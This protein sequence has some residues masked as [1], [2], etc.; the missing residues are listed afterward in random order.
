MPDQVEYLIT[1][2]I[3]RQIGQHALDVGTDQ[4]NHALLDHRVGDVDGEKDPGCVGLLRVSAVVLGGHA[5]VGT[6]TQFCNRKIKVIKLLRTMLWA[7]LLMA[8][9]SILNAR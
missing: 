2:G 8:E 7:A 3:T 9:V 1:I 5:L 4:L 6:Q